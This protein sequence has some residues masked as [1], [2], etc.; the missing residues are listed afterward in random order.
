MQIKSLFLSSIVLV[1]A[2]EVR[3]SPDQECAFFGHCGK[4]KGMTEIKLETWNDHVKIGWI[5]GRQRYIIPYIIKPQFEAY[6]RA[7]I[8]RVAPF[9]EG[10]TKYFDHTNV[11][12]QRFNERDIVGKNIKYVQVTDL[13]D[14]MSA[15]CSA[16]VGVPDHHNA[17]IVDIAGC[18]GDNA[19][20]VGS[21][22]DSPLTGDLNVGLIAHQF[23]HVLGFLH[24]HQRSDRDQY[25]TVSSEKLPFYDRV[26]Y[27][28]FQSSI[29]KYTYDFESIM[30]YKFKP[31]LMKPKRKYAGMVN[32]NGPIEVGQ[33]SRLSYL[34][35]MAVMDMFPLPR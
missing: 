7:W 21:N 34:D 16:D 12:F 33:L 1:Q 19:G 29:T 23:M 28:R 31:N 11:Y 20:N 14:K 27:D 10:A 18:L 6:P 25:V 32:K 22:T 17:N 15:G 5:Q 9:I 4:A 30:H 2:T 26:S 13:Y 8:N 3:Y 35:T 24:E